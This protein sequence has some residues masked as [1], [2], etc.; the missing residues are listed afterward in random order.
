MRRTLAIAILSG[1]LGALA[2]SSVFVR[3]QSV[4]VNPDKLR[5][6]L[7]GDEPIAGPDGQTF[8]NGWKVVVLKDLR[9]DQCYIAFVSGT[10][11]AV[12]GPAVCP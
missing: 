7:V 2:A 10:A 3:A 1:S 8:L 6:R 11:M 9:A 12:N 5:F 4:P